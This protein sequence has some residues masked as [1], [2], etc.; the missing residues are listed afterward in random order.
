MSQIADYKLPIATVKGG[1]SVNLNHLKRE[2]MQ[3]INEN[4]WASHRWSHPI[5]LFDWETTLG[6]WIMLQFPTSQTAKCKQIESKIV[7]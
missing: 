7:E 1:L 6:S 3:E 5:E 2:F 4:N